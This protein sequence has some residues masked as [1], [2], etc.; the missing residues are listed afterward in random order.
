MGGHVNT[1][2][3]DEQSEVLI[4][5]LAQGKSFSEIASALNEQF[6]TTYSRNAACGKGFRLKVTARPKIK[7]P[8]KERKRER[9]QTVK[10]ALRIEEIQLRCA[11]IEPR[12][13]TLDQ[14]EPDDCR[15]PFGDNPFTF[16][17]RLNLDGS[18]YCAEHS[19]LT[20]TNT[21]SNSDAVTAA[22]A[23]RMRGIN[24]RRS[25]LGAA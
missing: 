24:F 21:R 10:P 16:C 2:W 19:Q 20:V 11:E 25:L 7:A 22:R 13:L 17:G 14:L 15:Y 23:R 3:T 8:R 4:A 12:H 6:N 9:I 5:L 18:S 1:V